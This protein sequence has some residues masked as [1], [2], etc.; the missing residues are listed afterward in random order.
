MREE[1]YRREWLRSTGVY[2]QLDSGD[3]AMSR[4]YSHPGEGELH[5]ERVM[6]DFGDG[7]FLN[8]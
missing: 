7:S 5:T 2:P 3:A 1:Q 4:W 6:T 8:Q